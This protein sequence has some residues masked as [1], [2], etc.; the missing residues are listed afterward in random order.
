MYAPKIVR[1]GVALSFLMAPWSTPVWAATATAS[2]TVSA[3]LASRAS[4]TLTRGSSSVTRGSAATV[5]FDKPDDQDVTG[6][7]GAFMYAPYRSEASVGTGKNW[8]E[9][10]IVANGSTTTLSASVTGTAGSI[11][12][13]DIM[14]VFV[15][16]FFESGAAVEITGTKTPP[17]KWDR[18]DGYTKTVPQPFIGIV[19][20]NYRLR[21]GKVGAGTYTG[22]VTFTLTST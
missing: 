19:P 12:L 14:D 18:L 7:S 2:A 9:A 8:H 10:S 22:T 6:G 17:D 15:G 3:T 21:I 16:G 20:F 5:V 11:L 4:L 13:S 1:L